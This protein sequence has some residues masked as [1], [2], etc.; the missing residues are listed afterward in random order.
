M[1]VC[2]CI[3]MFQSHVRWDTQISD[4]YRDMTFILSHFTCQLLTRL[5][6]LGWNDNKKDDMVFRNVVEDVSKFLQVSRQDRN[7]SNWKGFG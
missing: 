2:L 5:T 4:V 1:Y 6:K 3:C 7:L